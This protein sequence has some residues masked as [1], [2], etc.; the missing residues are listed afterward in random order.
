MRG[1]LLAVVRQQRGQLV[2]ID[3]APRFRAKRLQCDPLVPADVDVAIVDS[4]SPGAQVD[5]QR[6]YFQQ[7]R[8]SAVGPSQQGAAAGDEFA[9]LERF[10]QIIVCAEVECVHAIVDAAAASEDE[11]GQ[12]AAFVA[13]ALDEAEPVRARQAEIDDG[14][15]NGFGIEQGTR[16]FGG[17][18]CEGVVPRLRNRFGNG[19]GGR[20]IVFDDK[21]AHG[22]AGYVIC[23]PLAVNLA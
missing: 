2:L 14:K 8:R 19:T 1:K 23:A 21:D 3:D 20:G 7:V 16:V 12:V 17:S 10:G 11:H 4:H 6:A 18:R 9:R 5:T 13:Q 22:G 15:I